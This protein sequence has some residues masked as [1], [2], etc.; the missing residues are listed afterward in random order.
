MVDRDTAGDGHAAPGMRRNRFVALA[1]A[2]AALALALRLLYVFG[3]KVEQPIAGDANQ[4]VLYA[5]NLVHDGTF[6]ASLPN[7]GPVVPDNM[8]GPGYPFVLAAAMRLCGHS[9][10]ALR[11]VAG[12]RFALVPVDAAWMYAVYAWQAF[13]GA[14]T[15]LLVIAI[16][17]RW[18]GRGAALGCGV[19]VALWP[20]LISFAGVLLS[21]T[22]FGFVIALA[23]WLLVLL[24]EHRRAWLAVCTGL[25]FAVAWLVNPVIAVFPLLAAMALLLR[26][27]SVV[28]IIVLASFAVA[29]AG[30]AWR[31]A[32]AGHLHGSYQRAA[33]NFVQGSWPEFLDAFNARHNQPLAAA[34]VGAE[35]DE[36]RVF[37]ANPRDGMA[38]VLAR[39]RAQPARYALWYLAQKPYLLWD[40]SV[41]VGWGDVYFLVTPDSPFTR[42]PVLRWMKQGF[43]VA[44]PAFFLLGAIAT[45]VL[46]WRFVRHPRNVPFAEGMA[47]L[48][49]IYLTAVHTV[50]QAEPRYSVPYRPEQMLMVVT[51]LVWLARKARRPRPAHSQA[52]AADGAPGDV[53][54]QD[55]GA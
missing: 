18:L 41:R 52:I 39:M 24:E 40:W 14:M 4:Y 9:D 32:A 5:W 28:A 12:G 25:A 19:L 31:N 7:A 26:G 48:L 54:P 10:L 21:E 34:L 46:G 6:S 44:N 15:V 50:L 51:A 22:V 33:Q 27:K 13:L 29:P 30:W 55:R 49:L 42:I 17:R 53:G 3:A 16:A 47:A 1:L 45:L 2:I 20:H 36:E 43:A 11:E 38:A 8:R 37:I 23:M 35:Q